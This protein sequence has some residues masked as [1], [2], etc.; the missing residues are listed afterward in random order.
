[1]RAISLIL[2]ILIAIQIFWFSSLQLQ[3]G[4]AGLNLVSTAYHFII[5]F[6]FSFF[7]FFTIKGKNKI[8]SSHIFATLIISVL[9]AISDEI[10]Q[11]FVPLR[12]AC[13][14]DVLTDTAGILIAALFYIFISKK[15]ET[16]FSPVQEDARRPF[17]EEHENEHEEQTDPRT[18]HY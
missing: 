11:L 8:K 15:T 18:S 3:G 12:S 5:F 14:T 17:A 1:M 9:Y 4:A 6:L 16:T 2:T 7:L 13:L 10:H